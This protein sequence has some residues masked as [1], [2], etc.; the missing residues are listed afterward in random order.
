MD[1]LEGAASFDARN[2][3]DL[4]QAVQRELMEDALT[5]DLPVRAAAVNGVVVLRGEVPTLEDAENAEAVASRVGGVREV[6]EEL[7]ITGL[8]RGQ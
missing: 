4:A 5:T 6:R 2:D 8:T 3:D 7:T 1:D